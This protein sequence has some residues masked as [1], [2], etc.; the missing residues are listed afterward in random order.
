[1]PD[2]GSWTDEDLD[3]LLGDLLGTG[4]IV[5]AA[6]VA[7]GGMYYLYQYAGRPVPD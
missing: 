1:M 6:V 2:R 7:L 3:R 5:S 4:V